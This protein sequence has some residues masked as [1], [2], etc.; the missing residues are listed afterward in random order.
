MSV[1]ITVNGSTRDVSAD[2]DTPLLYILQNDLGRTARNLDAGWHSA[3]HA[4]SFSARMP[5]FLFHSSKR[6]GRPALTTLE[7]LGTIESPHPLQQAF[8]R[9]QPAAS[10]VRILH[11]RSYHHVPCL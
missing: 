7:G 8:I 10:A 6:G 3:A 2:P 4:K 1:T 11:K 5:S 9:E